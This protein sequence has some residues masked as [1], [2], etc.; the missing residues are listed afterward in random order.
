M[1]DCSK[2]FPVWVRL[3][4]I[5]SHSKQILQTNTYILAHILGPS[6]SPWVKSAR[7]DDCWGLGHFPTRSLRHG[8]LAC[9]EWAGDNRRAAEMTALLKGVLAA[10]LLWVVLPMVL[11]LQKENEVNVRV[12]SKR[13]FVRNLDGYDSGTHWLY[14]WHLCVGKH[15]FWPT[16]SD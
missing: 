9:V 6:L 14:L 12:C 4:S 13:H 8:V 11:P 10:A 15:N 2:S 7:S 3:H 16:Q 1:L 5:F